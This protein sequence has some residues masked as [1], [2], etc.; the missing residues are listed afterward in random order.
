MNWKYL[1]DSYEIIIEK[2]PEAHLLFRQTEYILVLD[3][4]R[5][6]MRLKLLLSL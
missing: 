3:F 2:F 5:S 1:S 6:D 4:Q